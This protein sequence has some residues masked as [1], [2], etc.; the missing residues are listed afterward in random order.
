MT[1]P[2]RGPIEVPTEATVIELHAMTD[3][4]N[5]VWAQRDPYAALRY[6]RDCVIG[7]CVAMTIAWGE[8]VR[9]GVIDR[10][11]PI[12]LEDASWPSR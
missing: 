10:N 8:L 9:L 1:P 4:M 2:E 7:E 11:R 12:G 3:H 5:P 6:H